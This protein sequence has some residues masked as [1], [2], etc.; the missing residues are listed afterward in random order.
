V[1]VFGFD[2]VLTSKLL[3]TS[4]MCPLLPPPGNVYPKKNSK[5]GDG[6]SRNLG[7]F[8]QINMASHTRKPKPLFSLL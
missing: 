7:N 8:S 1:K 4:L 2:A 6:D 3:L 5:P